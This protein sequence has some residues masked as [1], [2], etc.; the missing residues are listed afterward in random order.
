MK[1]FVLVDC[2]NFFVSCERIFNPTLLGKPV[3]V[4]SS[5]D[6]CVIAR[7]NEAKAL[8]IA[9][10]VPAYECKYIFAR[11]KVIV[12]SA[13]FPL[14][15]DISS[16]VMQTLAEFCTDIEVYSV[17]ES[18]LVL[19]DYETQ[20]TNFTNKDTFYTD[21]MRY[22]KTEVKKHTGIP[23][24]IGKGPTKTLAKIANAI[25][26]KNLQ[27]NGVFDITNHPALDAI[28]A[29]M[30]VG[31][32]WGVGYRYTKLLKS[33]GI[34]TIADFKNLDERWVRK[35][36][37]INGLK[38]L[39]ELRGMPCIELQDIQPDKQSI[40][41]SR[42]FGQQVTTLPQLQEA[43]AQYVTQAAEKLRNQRMIAHHITVFITFTHYHA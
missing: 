5:N 24:S 40:T 30:D 27:Y 43:V 15:G 1:H 7:S 13:N 32:I 28:L 25:A 33:R 38:T 20:S 11:H 23:V 37:T 14:Y 26:K 12:C 6:A 16:R 29:S 9:M 34:R 22:I 21:Y 36:M 2:N 17:D 19:P 41:V 8:G 4:L 42:S 3:V 18:F 31:D 10:G 39:Y 35:H